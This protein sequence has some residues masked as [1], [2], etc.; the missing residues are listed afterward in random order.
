MT[1]WYLDWGTWLSSK[2]DVFTHMIDGTYELWWSRLKDT[3]NNRQSHCFYFPR[4]CVYTHSEPHD[5]LDRVRNTYLSVLVTETMWY[6]PILIELLVV[7]L[8]LQQH[9]SLF[10]LPWCLYDDVELFQ[11]CAWWWHTKHVTVRKV[12]PTFRKVHFTTIRVTGYVS[13]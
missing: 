3:K 1:Y 6:Q 7:L 10:L 11:K 9:N 2:N 8:H 4:N 5:G 13:W 12:H